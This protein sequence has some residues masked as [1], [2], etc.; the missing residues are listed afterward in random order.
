M[1]NAHHNVNPSPLHDHMQPLPFDTCFNT[2]PD[3]DS[4]QINFASG[5]PVKY[6]KKFTS[7]T[8]LTKISRA[9]REK[10]LDVFST[11]K[12]QWIQNGFDDSAPQPAEGPGASDNNAAEPTQHPVA[13][14]ALEDGV[15]RFGVS[16][17][18]GKKVRALGHDLPRSSSFKFQC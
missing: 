7:S 8:D 18:K 6:K 9:D 2:V 1:F 5:L 15:A 11:Y 12:E 13:K 3:I 4:N 14:L 16:G 10:F 17:E